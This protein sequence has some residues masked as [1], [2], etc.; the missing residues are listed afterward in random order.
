MEDRKVATIVTSEVMTRL[1]EHNIEFQDAVIDQKG[2]DGMLMTLPKAVYNKQSDQLFSSQPSTV[3]CPEYR[4]EGDTLSVDRKSNVYL[5]TGRVRF[6]FFG[7]PKP[8]NK[9]AATT[10]SPTPEPAAVPSPSAIPASPPTK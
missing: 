2:K 4:V 3:E 6:M 1:D 9:T 10:A 5:M 7:A 8:E